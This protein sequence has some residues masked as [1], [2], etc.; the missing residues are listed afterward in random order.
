[1]NRLPIIL[2]FSLGLYGCNSSFKPE[3]MPSKPKKI[4]IAH[5]GASGYLPEHTMASK[6]MAY[7]MQADF[8]EQDLVLSKDNV[9]IVIHDIYLEA[10]TDV[11]SKF[12]G[13]K[14]AD[15]HYYVI[16][17]AFAEL[18]KLQVS[19]R[20]DPKTGSA[21]Y[22]GRFPLQKSTFQLHSLQEEIE[23]IQGLNK[24]TGNNVG[25]YP[26]IKEPAFHM[27]EGKDISKIVLK[28][29]A[30]YGYTSKNDNC[31]LQCF[32]PKELKRIRKELSSELFLVQ[33]IEFKHDESKLNEIATYVDGIGLW[34]KK[35]SKNFV[36]N[37]KGLGFL[38]H[39]YTFRA[40]DLGKFDSFDA[41]LDYGFNTLGLDGVF[42]DFPDKVVS[43]LQKQ[44]SI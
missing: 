10:V 9:P 22:D 41:L 17:F 14:R 29:L 5:R 33:L 37:A 44:E 26:E 16:D 24:N 15:G 36:K 34:Y 31:V 43:F 12:P 6:A 3:N 21:V 32:D 2:L 7:A 13:R 25:I 40:D 27:Q 20:F 8:L 1:M 11:A 18:K 23:L 35:T 38:V 28:V 39:G 4:V 30:D 42:T 19:E